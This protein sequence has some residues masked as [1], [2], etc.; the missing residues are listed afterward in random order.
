MRV[1][2]QDLARRT[3]KAAV[4]VLAVIALVA[5]GVLASSG[6]FATTTRADAEREIERKAP[7]VRVAT[8]GIST[9]EADA[10]VTSEARIV[11]A[12]DHDVSP[13]V[14]SLPRPTDDGTKKFPIE[15]EGVQ[16]P[17][18]AGTITDPVVQSSSTRTPSLQMPSTTQNFPGISNPQGYVPPD[19][20]GDV[21]PNHYVQT[22]NVAMRVWNKDGTPLTAVADVNSLWAGFGGLCETTNQGDPIVLYDAIADRWL[23]SQFAFSGDGSSAPFYQC[24]AV[25]TSPNPAGTYYRYSFVSPFSRF[26][27]YG[28]LGVW[29]DAYYMS[30]NEFSTAGAYVGVGAWAFDR[31][32]MLSG[33]AATMQYFHLGSNYSNFLPADLD[34]AALPPSGAPNPF[35]AFDD[36][37]S[38]PR[39]K[40]LNFH[41]DWG[42]PASSTFVAAPDIIPATFDSNLCGGSSCVGQPGTS[43][44]LDAL[45]DRLMFR[46]AY[47]NFG[48]HQSMV[49]THAVD[50][51]GA[52]RAGVRWYELRKTGADWGIQQQG[53]YAPDTANRFMSSA[54]MDAGGNIAVGYSVSSGSVYPGLRYAGRL[55]GDPAGQLSQGET[56]LV[57]GAG[58]Q[59]GG[60]G[61]WGDYSSMSIDPSDDCTF[62]YTSEYY[63][64][65]SAQGWVTRI[66]SFKFPSCSGGGGGGGSSL[67]IGDANVTEGNAGST[68][69]TFPVT[70]SPAQATAVTVNYATSAGTAAA[71]SDFTTTSGTLT[72]APN[73][74]Q[75]NINVPVIGDTTAESSETF[76]VTLSGASAGIT[77]ADGQGTGTITDD[78]SGTPVNYSLSVS[79]AGTGSGT[80]TSSPSGISCGA[81]CSANYANGTTVTLTASASSGST[82]SG[83]SGACTGTGSCVVSMSAARSVTATFDGSTTSDVT[84]TGRLAGGYGVF[85][86]YTYYH[87]YNSVTYWGTA[88]PNLAGQ[89]LKFQLYRWNGWDWIAK[90]QWS[91][92]MYSDSTVGI[93]FSSYSLTRGYYAIK[94]SYAGDGTHGAATSAWS[95]FRVTS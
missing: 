54:A 68:S 85:S 51:N 76:T 16:P 37:T 65:T 18:E 11:K 79:K 88:T 95:Y 30:T 84:V 48:S 6:P 14:R 29:P 86:G 67:S 9:S 21:G 19:T 36:W 1:G 57:A 71:G 78:D 31:T 13:A 12:A 38:S 63:T 50:S 66:G 2:M 15:F 17:S 23:I 25:S 47:R 3:S 26:P 90:G 35:V 80:V 69:A 52:D 72:F 20:N 53:T 5:T 55:A 81:T 59:T 41:V 73:E 27:D 42:T 24:V 32:K 43:N 61:R 89:K 44:K 28:K 75:K 8:S 77:I 60:G 34:G 93:R 94:C 56:V 49:V 10:T 40:V 64:S 39:L 7:G 91:Y 22:V 70:L 45:S 83:W 58:S 74:T 33:Q 92:P 4:T 87:E 82:F 46:L 62:W